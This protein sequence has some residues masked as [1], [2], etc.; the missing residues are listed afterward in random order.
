[1]FARMHFFK[2]TYLVYNFG[3]LLSIIFKKKITKHKKIRHKNLCINIF[4][5]SVTYKKANFCK[6][7]K[8]CVLLQPRSLNCE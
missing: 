3:G 6:I 1:M 5:N 8:F 7:M 4:M 2:S